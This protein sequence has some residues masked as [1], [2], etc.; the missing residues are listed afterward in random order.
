MEKFT[1]S[2]KRELINKRSS[3]ILQESSY[4]IKTK[5]QIKE[6]EEDFEKVRLEILKSQDPNKD[7]Y[8]AKRFNLREQEEISLV[9]WKGEIISFSSLYNRDGYYPQDVSRVL[10]RMWKSP[11][12]RFLTQHY[13]IPFI[14]LSKQL[15]QAISLKKSAVFISL[16]GKKNWLRM[17]TAYLKEQDERWVYCEEPYKI[18]PGKEEFCWQN[19][20]YLSFQPRYNFAPKVIPFFAKKSF[21]L[22][23]HSF[24]SDF[25]LEKNSLK[26]HWIF[27]YKDSHTI[28]SLV[29]SL[30]FKIG[31]LWKFLELKIKKSWYFLINFFKRF[32]KYFLKYFRLNQMYLKKYFRRF[33]WY[34]LKYLQRFNW[35]LLN[36][37]DLLKEY[38]INV[39]KWFKFSIKRIMS[40]IKRFIGWFYSHVLLVLF[41]RSPPMKLYYFSEYQY[42][43]RI[44]SL[45]RKKD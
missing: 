36:W 22:G 38:F 41:H 3:L 18:A 26:A 32:Q 9:Y 17:L 43:K 44:R 8:T 33:K 13:A 40:F 42:H 16:F 5:K 25:K 15:N 29:H 21:N 39:K 34:F 12:I 7:N 30:F 28:Y 14:M 24:E 19:V 23:F 31:V 20:S 45:L 2:S 10:N 4:I 1:W 37:F 27:L 6:W 11:K 35:H